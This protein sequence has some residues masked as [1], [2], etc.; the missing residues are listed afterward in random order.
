M[1][2]TYVRLLEQ[3]TIAEDN[4]LDFVDFVAYAMDAAM[5]LE[6]LQP[7]EISDTILDILEKEIAF[8]LQENAK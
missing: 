2:E 8:N 7:S 4:N 1:S 3:Q 5:A 6:D